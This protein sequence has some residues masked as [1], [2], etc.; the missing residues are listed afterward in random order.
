[1]YDIM[2]DINMDIKYIGYDI[3]ELWYHKFLI[4]FM[5]DHDIIYDVTSDI[6]IDIKDIGYDIIEL[7]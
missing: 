4:S 2:Y 3:I 7:W 1:M 6:N 5:Q